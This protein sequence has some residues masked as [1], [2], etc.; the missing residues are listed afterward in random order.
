MNKITDTYHYLLLQKKYFEAFVFFRKITV[1]VLFILFYVFVSAQTNEDYRKL[2]DE[3]YQDGNYYSSGVFY[4]ILL[5]K[6]SNNLEIA[7]QYANANRL[8]NNYTEA[9]FWYSFVLEKDNEGKFPLSGFYQAE[10]NKYNGKYGLAIRNYKYYY[11]KNKEKKDYY[12]LKSFQEINSCNWASE[13]IGDTLN[14]EITHLGKNINTPYSEFGAQQLGDSMLVYSSLRQVVDNEFESFLPEAYLS[15]LYFSWISVAG[16]SSGR[17]LNG[18]INSEDIHTANLNIDTKNF[19][20]YFTRCSLNESA[21]MICDIYTSDFNDGKWGKPTKLNGK[22]NSPGYTSTQPTITSYNGN[23]ILYFSS[24]RPG[25][26]GQMDLW[27][28]ISNNGEF[29]QPVNLGSRINTAG[30]EISPFY[31]TKSQKLYFSSDWHFGFGG[32]DIFSSLGSFNQWTIPENLGFPINTTYNDLYF[33]VNETANEGYLTSNRKG[34]Y[35]IKGETC[36]NDIYAYKLPEKKIEIKKDTLLKKESITI[37]ESIRKLLP[38][39]LYFHN[40]EPTPNNSITGTDKNYKQC[41]AD[42]YGMKNIYKTAYSKGLNKE[43]SQKAKDDIE[44]FFINE[45]SKGFKSLELFAGLLLR[46]LQKGNEIRITVKGYASPLNSDEYNI[47][48][49]KRRIV[50]LQNYLKEYNDGVL[51]PYLSDT[52]NVRG[53]LIIYEEP[54]GKSMA[55]KTV[56]DNP[57][58]LRN[59]VYSKAAAMERKIQILYYDYASTQVI[60][61]TPQIRFSSDSLNYGKLSRQS[62]N[63]FSIHFK[64]EGK[65]PFTI[66]DISSECDCM[67]YYFEETAILPGKEGVINLLIIP[68]EKKGKQK[69]QLTITLLPFNTKYILSIYYE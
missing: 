36:C 15:K 51:C 31:D 38:L 40:D 42:Y 26:F 46:D 2:A 24:N 58:D 47:N 19:R 65:F 69:R 67:K 8:Y 49:T 28:S 59:S 32:Y 9:E 44:S 48:L 23:D 66:K 52:S 30:N 11:N 37:E 21:E 60:D 50:S 56:S 61:S 34:S 14:V 64:N 43:E 4:K 41:L 53:K 62:D 13:K 39:T 63:A 45:V 22:I 17:A 1:A 54:L 12:T 3:A 55:S 6:D 16:Y 5:N 68:D 29:Q 27:Y 35:F 20:A 25:G 33:S 57:N 10:M 18:K 7:Y